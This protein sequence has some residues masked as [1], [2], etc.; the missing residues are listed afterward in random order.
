MQ[1]FEDRRRAGIGK[2]FTSD[3]LRSQVH[4]P[5][6]DV[7]SQTPG[8]RLVRRPT[9]CG[10]GFAV[11]TRGATTPQPWMRC[12]TGD[13]FPVA[14]YVSVFLDGIS[15]YTTGSIEPIDLNQFAVNGLE[16]IELYRGPS[17]TPIQYQGTGSACGALLLWTRVGSM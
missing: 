5:L 15:L 1:P 14:C 16:A 12:A 9:R 17:E 3:L 6:S 13:R 10:A 11:A 2:F 7:L 8:V 4:R